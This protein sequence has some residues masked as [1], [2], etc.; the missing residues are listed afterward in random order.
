MPT[1]TITPRD[2][3]ETQALGAG[4]RITIAIGILGTALPALL[5]AFGGLD[6]ITDNLAMLLT[7]LGSLAGGGLAS[8][9]A[10][11]RM[12]VDKA[13]SA[14]KS[15]GTASALLMLLAIAPLF[16]GCVAIRADSDKDG[17]AVW[18]FGW[19]A[20][21]AANLANVAVTGPGSTDMQTG[22]SF[23]S[24]GGTQS[25]T[26][27]I[28]GILQ[29]GAALAP[30]LAGVPAASAVTSYA[31]GTDSAPAE[32]PAA[33]DADVAA[34]STAYDTTGYDGSPGASGEGVYGR[35]SCSRC[36]AY[37]AAH[38]D[39]S[40]VNVDDAG[41]RADLWA[42]LRLRGFTGSTVSLPVLVTETSYTQSAK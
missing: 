41:N 18:A 4:K 22:V 13:A 40:I 9:I 8:Y 24:G 16:T 27:A 39:T 19:G 31:A 15:A 37:K 42:A 38:P 5:A 20:E 25:T 1:D 3:R 32:A 36:R 28:R 14:G 35:P 21:S 12:K 34:A 17:A 10:V 33:S 29:L 6:W 7:G 26:E 30:V 23:D 11:R 2:A